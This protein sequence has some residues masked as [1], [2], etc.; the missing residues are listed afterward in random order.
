MLH[1]FISL[2]RKSMR[3]SNMWTIQN[4]TMDT[5]SDMIT[6]NFNNKTL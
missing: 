2:S 6:Q 1:M 5:M 4:L 3:K